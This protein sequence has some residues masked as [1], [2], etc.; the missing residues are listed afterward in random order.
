LVFAGD[1]C[2]GGTKGEWVQFCKWLG[3]L[4]HRH[5]LVV[6]GNHD[7]C[8]QAS[9]PEYERSAKYG[10]STQY[11]ALDYLD[12]ANGE[13]LH[14]KHTFIEGLSVYGSGWC[15]FFGDWAYMISPKHR[16]TAWRK[17]PDDLDLLIT[18]TP[19]FGTLDVSNRINMSVGCEPLQERLL[20]M[21][22]SA[23]SLHVFG[24][25]H[26][27]RGISMPYGRKTI[28]A[29]VSIKNPSGPSNTP[30]V[31]DLEPGGEPHYVSS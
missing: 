29:N 13:F 4:P 19:P 15:S 3:S 31:F 26:E 20:E 5:K 10:P 2:V 30:V 11:W 6:P 24:H 27:S 7:W 22:D 14:D 18:H 12:K 25:V 16:Q 8:L 9:Y 17:I 1:A 21:G 23:P 28:S